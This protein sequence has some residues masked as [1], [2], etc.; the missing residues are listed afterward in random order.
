MITEKLGLEKIKTIGDAYMC[1]GG[2][3]DA[4]ETHMED[5]LKAA[6][7]IIDYTEQRYLAKQAAGKAYWRARIGIHV[8]PV[9]TGV[10]GSRKFQ[11]DIWGDTV[12]TAARM[13]S[14]SASGKIN[15]SKAACDLLQT[16][17]NYTFESRGRIE[18]KGKGKMEM[19][20]VDLLRKK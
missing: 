4:R 20:F 15:V 16:N 13:E 19:F 6:F 17:G 8:G 3:P 5:M 12:N 1:A 9:I 2:I 10:V 7:E 14:N 18:V 11:Y